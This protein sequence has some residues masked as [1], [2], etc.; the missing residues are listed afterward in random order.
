MASYTLIMYSLQKGEERVKVVTVLG[1]C[2]ESIESRYKFKNY[3]KWSDRGY[4]SAPEL[5]GPE[6]GTY[7]RAGSR[8]Q[9]GSF[10]VGCIKQEDEAEWKAGDSCGLLTGW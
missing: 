4:Y 10:K 8:P 7:S 2:T 6:Q 3:C 5:Q 9:V 1:G